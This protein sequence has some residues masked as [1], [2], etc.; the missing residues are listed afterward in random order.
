[1]DNDPALELDLP[2]DAR[3]VITGVPKSGKTTTAQSLLHGELRHTD[4]LVETHEWSE[5]S[6]EVT[7]WMQEPGPW[8][9]EGVTAIRA[10]RKFCRLHEGEAP[11]DV[12]L[13]LIG[14]YLDLTDGQERMAKG[15]ATVANEILPE[16]RELGVDVRVFHHHE[17]VEFDG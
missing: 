13:F 15:C 2:A 8:T 7:R 4:D 9:I 3:L 17:P 16:L 6:L 5:A 14:S 11:C 12:V 10:L 1:M